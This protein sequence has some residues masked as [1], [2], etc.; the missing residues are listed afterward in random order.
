MR[1][2]ANTANNEPI[3]SAAHYIPSTPLN[4]NP[5]PVN[6]YFF[7][8][9]RLS[10]VGGRFGYLLPDF[11][12]VAAKMNLGHPLLVCVIGITLY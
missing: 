7:K 1:P 11:P 3:Q 4:N 6:P 9:K 2:V 5:N 12:V 10:E 8:K